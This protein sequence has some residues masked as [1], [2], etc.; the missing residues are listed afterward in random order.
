MTSFNSQI[1]R[2]EDRCVM[3]FETD[4]LG[5]LK[6]MEQVARCLVDGAVAMGEVSDG[7]H[8]FNELYYHR[9]VLFAVICNEHPPPRVEKQAPPHRGYVRR[10][11]YRGTEYLARADLLSL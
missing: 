1:L 4:D 10:Y 2:D 6:I 7:Y 9:A 3:H 5:K 11:V 8:T